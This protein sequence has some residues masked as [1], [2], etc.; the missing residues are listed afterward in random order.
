MHLW[1][2]SCLGVTADCRLLTKMLLLVV[3]P[4]RRRNQ[5]VKMRRK[6]RV[7]CG[8]C[9]VFLREAANCGF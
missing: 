5:T 9:T 7:C 8:I 3:E 2:E 1:P 4:V 6:K